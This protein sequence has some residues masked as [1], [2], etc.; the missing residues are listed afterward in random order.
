MEK[1]R[2]RGLSAGEHTFDIVFTDGSVSTKLTISA[3]QTPGGG[4]FPGWAV[5]LIIIGG[6]L[7][8]ASGG[9]AVYWF[10]IKKKSFS[11]LFGK[12]KA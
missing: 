6:V 11:D 10:V 7:I 4:G 1:E 2:G 12:K 9:F 5:A 3:A 8:L